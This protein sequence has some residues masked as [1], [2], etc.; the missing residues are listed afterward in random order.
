MYGLRS[1]VY[2]TRLYYRFRWAAP[3]VKNLFHAHINMKKTND[4]LFTKSNLYSLNL[5]K[6]KT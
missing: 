1:A 3:V 5:S 2:S 6:A 4:S